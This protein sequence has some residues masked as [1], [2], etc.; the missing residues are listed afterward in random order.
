MKVASCGGCEK[1]PVPIRYI[2]HQL[3]WNPD[4]IKVALAQLSAIDDGKVSRKAVETL[5]TI[6]AATTLAREVKKAEAAGNPIPHKKQEQ[7]AK[8]ASESVKESPARVIE[9]EVFEVSHPEKG[10]QKKAKEFQD[11]LGE[12]AQIGR[13][14]SRAVEKI[15][16][17]KDDLDS[18]TYRNTIGAH[19]FKAV[20]VEIQSHLSAVLNRKMER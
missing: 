16:Q 3:D 11:Y 2:H 10:N 6:H 13:K 5:P 19:Y 18:E 20:C 8:R 1:Y 7:I 4:R 14:F 15:I 9:Q 17:F 12:T